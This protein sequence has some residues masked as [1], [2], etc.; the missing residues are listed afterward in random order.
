MKVFSQILCILFLLRQ[1]IFADCSISNDAVK[2][3]HF[4]NG[5]RD[6]AIVPTREMRAETIYMA[7]CM[8]ELHYNHKDLSL[9]DNKE[10]LI[11]YMSELDLHRMFWLQQDIDDFVKRFASTL[12]IFVSGGSLMPAFTIFDHYR[13]TVY[14]RLDW[15]KKRLAQEWNFSSDETYVPDR[16]KSSWPSNKL[17][18][19]MLWEKR[20]KYELINEMMSAEYKLSG[21]EESQHDSNEINAEIN[22]D[23]LNSAIEII[24]TRYENLRNALNDFDSWLIEEIF[25]NSISHMY[26]PHSSFLSKTSLEDFNVLLK[27][28]LVGIGATLMD[29]NGTCVIKGLTPGGPASLS[30][31]LKIGDKILAVAQGE[32]GNFVDIVGMRLYKSVKLIRG[33]KGTVVRLKIQPVDAEPGHYQVISLVRDEIQLNETRA[34]GKLFSF[35]GDKKEQVIKIGVIVLP[36]FYGDDP[37]SAVK[38]ADTTSD[39]KFLIEEMKNRGIDGLVI[40]L[41]DN[42]GGFLEQAITVSGLFIATGPVVQVR[43]SFGTIENLCDNDSNI[44]WEGPLIVLTSSN[45]ASASEILVGALHDHHRAIIVGDPTTHGK[46]SVQV[47]LPMGQYFNSLYNKDELGAARVTV[48]KWY[49]PTGGST[50][51]KGV[52]ADIVLPSIEACLPVKESDLPHALSWDSIPAAKFDYESKAKEHNYFVDPSLIDF[53]QGKVNYRMQFLTEFNL[54]NEQIEHF[55]QNL[56]QKEVSLNLKERR[57]NSMNDWEFKTKIKKQLETLIATDD[58]KFEKISVSEDDIAE[59]V[60][61]NTKDLPHFDIQ[62][63]ESLRI[64][65]D[66]VNKNTQKEALSND[67]IESD[68]PLNDTVQPVSIENNK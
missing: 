40:D 43:D 12:D 41:R 4:I 61:T 62:L 51:L 52:K 13:K 36:V 18:A 17:E 11:D 49:L 28:V 57:Q 38:N 10:I 14:S 59:D 7:R 5:E 29:D 6:N 32:D 2:N 22:Q 35:A 33:E 19:D 55:K 23:N 54:L 24:S 45:S 66:W 34:S 50:Q 3:E 8:E 46:G 47:I 48:Q 56:D 67:E 21:N 60:G 58:Y 27:H 39:M 63:R 44:A 26:D 1:I 37:N 68:S 25:L 16:R 15:I 30:K 65:C 53:L 64:M 31:K 20:L 42:S 9:L